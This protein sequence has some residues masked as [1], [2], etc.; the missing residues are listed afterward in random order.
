MRWL[1]ESVNY[2]DG[3]THFTLA[4][5]LSSA[6]SLPSGEPFI[7]SEPLEKATDLLGDV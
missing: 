2:F 5:V 1:N 4:D 3:K 6:E 7:Y